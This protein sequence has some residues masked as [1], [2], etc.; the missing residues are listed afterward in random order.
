[1]VWEEANMLKLY[2]MTAEYQEACRTLYDMEDILEDA[3]KDT[4]DGLKGAIE[5]KIKNVLA[6]SKDLKAESE[7]IKTEVD[8][9][10]Q[11]AKSLANRAEWFKQY[12]LNH[13]LHNDIKKIN[14]PWFPIRIQYSDKVEVKDISLLPQKYMIET[15][16]VAVDKNAIKR[17]LKAG[18]EISGAELKHEPYLVVN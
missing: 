5:D 2:E 16:N 10:A 8:K 13:M 14:C 12:A 17:D 3:V 7:A 1:M 15:V 4:L 6:F 18:E 9:M 11:R